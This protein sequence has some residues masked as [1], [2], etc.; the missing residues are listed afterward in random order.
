VVEYGRGRGEE[1]VAYEE[2]CAGGLVEKK[3]KKEEGT[4]GIGIRDD[5]PVLHLYRF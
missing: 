2:L 4:Y 1:A 5:P 3:G